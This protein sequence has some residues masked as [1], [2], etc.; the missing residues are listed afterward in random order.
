MIDVSFLSPPRRWPVRL[1]GALRRRLRTSELWLIALSVAVGGAAGLLAVF[2]SRIAHGMI[3][4]DQA[5]AQH[6]AV[7]YE[8]GFRRCFLQSR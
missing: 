7:A 8:F 6:Q 3:T 1:A 5:R 2:Q 4:A